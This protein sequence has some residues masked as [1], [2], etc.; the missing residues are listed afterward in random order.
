MGFTGAR[1]CK[2]TRNRLTMV[3]F[4]GTT[5]RVHQAF[6]G[7]PDEVLRAMVTFFTCRRSATRRDARRVILDHA[8]ARPAGPAK[9]RK[10]N[11][12]LDPDLAG[13]LATWHRELNE[14][15]FKG[16]LSPIEPHVSRRMRSRLGHYSPAS[17]GSGAAAEIV[18]SRRH[19]A[20]DGLE[21]ARDTLL[22]E[23]VHQWQDENGL[24][25]SHG[26][27]F[28]RKAREVGTAPYARRPRALSFQP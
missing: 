28:R 2:L 23:M 1:F 11:S 5:L 15:H 22:H 12:G 3:S 9:R 21:R 18:I 13:R 24:P 14:R 19:M 4:S 10:R 6:I 27:D 7:A 8:G 17:T 20:R 25:L 26:A 16:R